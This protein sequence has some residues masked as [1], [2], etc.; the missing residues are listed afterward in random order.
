MSNRASDARAVHVNLAFDPDS[1]GGAINNNPVVTDR[2]NKVPVT[3]SWENLEVQV[4][5]AQGTCF[6]RL[7][8]KVPPVRKQILKNVTGAV[9]P[10][11]FLAIMGASGAG[12][13]TLLNCLTHRN[14]GSLQI[15]GKRLING[16]PI[17][18]DSLARISGYVQ[19]DDL[20]V[21]T[22]TVRETLR[23][24][25]ILRMD[26]HLTYD[27]RMNR[28]EE[29]IKE[30]GLSNCANTKI[31]NPQRGIKGISGG[32]S[33]RLAF[34][35]EVL[36]D[37]SL[38]FCDEPTSG[39]DSYMAQSIVEVLRNLAAKGKTVICTIHQP[40]SEVFALFDRILLM[41]QGRTAFL[42]PID[43][44]LSFFSSQGLPCPTNY[45]P[46]D[47]YIFSLATVFDQES[48]SMKKNMAICDA[49]EQ[50]QMGQEMLEFV[51]AK[52]LQTSS[53][54]DDVSLENRKR[55]PYKASWWNQS[56]AVLWR[57]WMTVLRD[58]AFLTIKAST[59]LIVALLVSLIYQ[60]QSLTVESIPNIQGVLF[61][62]LTTAN[63]SNVF[64]VINTFTAELPIFLREHFNGM[65]S[66]SVYFVCK[67]IAESFI[68]ILVPFIDFGVPY[69]I[70]GL[71]PAAE[72]FFRGAA[73]EILVANS[74]VSFG[75]F[76][77]CL[78]G[79]TQIA[80]AIAG[81][82]NI[83]LLLFGGFFLKNNTAPKWLSFFQYLSWFNYG[84]EALTINQWEG[85]KFN[86]TNCNTTVIEMLDI[87]DFS[88]PCT[89]E[90]VINS[91][92][93]NSAFLLRDILL[94]V[95]LIVGLRTL[96]FLALLRRSYGNK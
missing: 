19:Q 88:G 18:Q 23:F 84:N 83:P 30:L 50:S 14:S 46:A 67:M 69:F 76:V 86:N 70:I 90:D 54:M 33:K 89:G 91:Y 45:N 35:N 36:T 22:L 73:I 3:Y 56:R 72:R 11:E 93:F 17:D 42:G 59:A 4:D 7:L 78:A 52:P 68:Y 39:L 8:K 48:E 16:K 38:L 40:S 87:R 82:L 81:P 63:F 85:V 15:T 80:L 53:G 32:E 27:E 5:V 10:G 26:K 13:T 92:N 94:L 75:Y 51:R 34:A 65:Y 21:G 24:Q 2:T 44:A 12:K 6:N 66:T 37:P 58:P 1:E 64:G 62:F 43:A 60:G 74:A 79:T 25:A 61:L 20:F 96:A 41:A 28:V 29:V 31:G 77:S 57:S 9:R 49:Y 47:F 95:A 71:N 55:S